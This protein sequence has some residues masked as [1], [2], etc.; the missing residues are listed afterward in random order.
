MAN[1]ETTEPAEDEPLVFDLEDPNVPAA[2]GSAIIK[3]PKRSRSQ[4]GGAPDPNYLTGVTIAGRYAIGKEIGRGGMGVVYLAQQ[5]NL[6]R[7]VVVKVL[8]R[9]MVK[10]EDA[11]KRFD[12]EARGMSAL[13]H[14]NLVTIYDYGTHDDLSYIVMEYVD[15]ESLDQMLMRRERVYWADFLRIAVQV[16]DAVGEAH[17]SGIIHRDL[18][19]ANVMLCERH[20]QK[21][22]VKILDFGLARFR[23]NKEITKELFGSVSYLSPEI[24]KG[25]TVDSRADVY[26][27]GCIFYEM[28]SGKKPFEG[29]DYGVMYKHVNDEPTPL[30]EL[31]P[32]DHLV[33]EPTLRLIHQCLAKDKA[34]RPKDAN[35]LLQLL[36]TEVSRWTGIL[37]FDV[38]EG[39]VPPRYRQYAANHQTGQFRA[40]QASTATTTNETRRA[41]AA[42][43]PPPASS[44]RWI[45]VGV[46]LAIAVAAI[47]VVAWPRAESG[48]T[49]P[50]A[51]VAETDDSAAIASSIASAESLVQTKKFGRAS[52][53]LDTLGDSVSTN[54]RF[55]SR[56]AS[57]RDEIAIEQLVMAAETAR[58]DG[59][60]EEARATYRKVLM[61][62]P[63]HQVAVAALN[64]LQAEENVTLAV[65]GSPAK[66]A[67][68]AHAAPPRERPITKSQRGEKPVDTGKKPKPP[69]DE[70]KPTVEQTT[71]DVE[72]DGREFE[73]DEPANLVPGEA[74]TKAAAADEPPADSVKPD[75]KEEPKAEAKPKGK[76]KTKAKPEEERPLLPVDQT[77]VDDVAPAETNGEP[78]QSEDEAEPKDPSEEPPREATGGASVGPGH[79]AQTEP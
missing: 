74:P 77:P 67:P 34:Q 12:R 33:P 8:S 63:N 27:L 69:E 22:F 43:P 7:E 28:L 10:D 4:A 55:A 23:S 36:T 60:A 24:I 68:V 49:E 47:A 1:D 53:L 72:F 59:N 61:R 56:V 45:P 35:E 21:N 14:P 11:R 44:N 30:D 64:E 20:G 31:L 54:P 58:A 19:P 26:A 37:P 38:L 51:P 75:E 66:T 71:T 13:Q 5:D 2:P 15:G 29:E 41:E 3:L 57:L 17:A 76:G 48:P 52:E 62:D 73:P 6:G 39:G 70:P 16:L 25:E 42:Q 50:V 40:V 46:A 65:K 78:E 18:K 79:R 32:F 9:E